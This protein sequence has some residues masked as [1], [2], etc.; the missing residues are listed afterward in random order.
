MTQLNKTG[1]HDNGVIPTETRCTE[2]NNKL[3]NLQRYNI[4]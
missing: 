3:N 1:L 4:P 2:F